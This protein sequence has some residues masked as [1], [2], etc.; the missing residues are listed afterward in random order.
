MAPILNYE[1]AYRTENEDSEKSRILNP[2]FS[3]EH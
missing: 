1:N 2:K 3:E